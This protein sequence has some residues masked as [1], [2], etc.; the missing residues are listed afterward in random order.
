MQITEDLLYYIWRYRLFD[1]KALNTTNGEVIEIIDTGIRNTNAGPDFIMS[2][3]R[4]N[5][6]LWVGN[7]EIHVKSSDWNMHGHRTDPAFNSVIL[8]IVWDH[9]LE[10]KNSL[11]QVI[12]SVELYTKVDNRLLSKY[13]YMMQNQLWVPCAN[14]ISSVSAITKESWLSRLMAERLE[15]K[16]KSILDLV[17]HNQRDWEAVCYQKLA[18]SLGGQVNGE[19]MELLARITPLHLLFKHRDQL[20]QIEALLFGQSGLFAVAD[21]PDEYVNKLKEEYSFLQLKYNLKP[22][23]ASQWKFLRMR[24]ANFPTLR[25]AQLARILFQTDFLFSKFLSASQVKEVINMLDVTVTQYW[26]NH[27][28]FNTKSENKDK[29][30][31]METINS[32][33]INT[34]SPL[35]FAYGISTA[36]ESY[37]ERAI[38]WLEALP[39]EKNTI[40]KGWAELNWKARMA[41]DSQALIQLKNNY[42][43]DKKCLQCNIGHQLI[44][45]N[46]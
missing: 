14:S 35:M 13:E 33:I 4:I 38:T 41:M 34:I 15:Q 17:D 44:K 30:L 8:H 45:S 42:C 22:L 5:S 46:I 19:I 31:G 24:P 23:E 1:F 6:Q 7:I 3:I 29:H 11:D 9:D 2:K 21:Q 26:R 27:Y 10:I 12:P 40:T 28:T 37:K 20:W 18:R 43:N 39:A 32:I 36:N 25:I 16:S